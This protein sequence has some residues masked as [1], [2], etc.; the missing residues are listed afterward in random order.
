MNKIKSEHFFYLGLAILGVVI[1]AM[2]F[3]QRLSNISLG[4]LDVGFADIKDLT[5][6]PAPPTE[7]PIDQDD[8][9][10]PTITPTPEATL[11]NGR[12][13]ATQ[14]PTAAP[15]EPSTPT[16]TVEEG[17]R[18]PVEPV[19]AGTSVLA[20]DLALGVD[21]NYKLLQAGDSK[22]AVQIA[23]LI[24]VENRG[25]QTQ[26][27]TFTRN[28]ITLKDDLGNAYDYAAGKPPE[29]NADQQTQI[30]AG[31][32]LELDGALLFE[33]LDPASLPAFEGP[34]NPGA[35]WLILS[36]EGC[37]PYNGVEVVIDL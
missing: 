26:L 22:P 28:A 29:L 25:N 32:T 35:A 13:T 17:I 10:A 14:E 36:F 34:I 21:P 23:V 33:P 2:V 9:S 12:S 15:P 27:L 4:P 3:G 30:A 18:N 8:P 11:N 24:T 6:T 1:I 37:G 5:N 16:P 19:P 20:G 7:P 31:E